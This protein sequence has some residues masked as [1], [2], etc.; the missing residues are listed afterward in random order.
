MC[1]NRKS[2]RSKNMLRKAYVELLL[3]G[4]EKITGC[5]VCERAGLSRNTMYTHYPNVIA[6]SNDV[7]KAFEQEVE[8]CIEDTGAPQKNGNP[9]TLLLHYERMIQDK[10]IQCRALS[11]TRWYGDFIKKL[12]ET[13]VAYM[14]SSHEEIKHDTAFAVMVYVVAGAMA[15][16][17]TKYLQNKLECSL[18]QINERVMQLYEEEMAKLK[19]CSDAMEADELYEPC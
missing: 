4:E 1:P 2:V 16:L 19:T 14:F 17:Y 11:H 18:E 7:W 10:E 6:L 3:L 9:R 8:Q 15:E 13:F 5:A 12:E